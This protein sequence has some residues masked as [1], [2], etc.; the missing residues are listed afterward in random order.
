MALRASSYGLIICHARMESQAQSR[1]GPRRQGP[2]APWHRLCYHCLAEA[3]ER[4]AQ[5]F[6]GFSQVLMALTYPSAM[7]RPLSLSSLCELIRQED[8]DVMWAKLSLL[9]Y[10]RKT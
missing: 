4:E 2:G 5:V 6:D 3:S 8:C 1:G 10:T 7:Y 9:P